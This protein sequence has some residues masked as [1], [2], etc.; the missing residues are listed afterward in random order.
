L[1]AQ[2]N[3][4]PA[5]LVIDTGAGELILDAQFA[6]TAGVI[7]G[8]VEE[9]WFAGGQAGLVRHGRIESLRLG[10]QTILA[11]PVELIELAGVFA[12]FLPGLPVHG[13]LGT[14]VLSHFLATLDFRTGR[15]VL[16]PKQGDISEA[17]DCADLEVPF[18]LAGDHYLLVEVTINRWH[19]ALVFLDTGMAGADLAVPHSTLHLANLRLTGGGGQ[20]GQGG[21]GPVSALPVVVDVLRLGRY[22]RQGLHGMVLRGFP[23]E[24]QFGFRLSGLLARDFFH[25]S[26]LTL[27]FQRMRLRIVG[28][29]LPS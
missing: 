6:R 27:D 23:L 13:I 4:I 3:G 10:G 11:L 18:W 8:G 22:E 17:P 21:G 9:G 2:V 7:Q 25:A 20:Q 15:L 12:P 28:E 26:E 5:H 14:A 24:Y 16:R 1:A 29:T 19:R